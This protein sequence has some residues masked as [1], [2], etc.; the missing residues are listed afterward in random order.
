MESGPRK[1]MRSGS[2]NKDKD[3]EFASCIPRVPTLALSV[4]RVALA[5]LP[6]PAYFPPHYPGE[7]T[8]A[9]DSS[10]ATTMAIDM[11]GSASASALR[12]SPAAAAAAAFD[13]DDEQERSSFSSSGSESDTEFA[14]EL[15]GPGELERGCTFDEACRMLLDTG[16]DDDAEEAT[17]SPDGPCALDW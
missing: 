2:Y 3:K 6:P 7:I 16:A 12:A 11:D 1:R 15:L 5:A 10:A 8:G 17:E 14:T 9:A 4:P 13:S